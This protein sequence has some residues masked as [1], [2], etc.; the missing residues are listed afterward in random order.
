MMTSWSKWISTDVLAAE[1]SP[2]WSLIKPNVWQ[3]Q[4]NDGHVIVIRKL[5]SDS[6]DNT[7]WELCYSTV[8][9]SLPVINQVN[10]INNGVQFSF[11]LCKIILTVCRRFTSV[12]FHLQLC[13]LTL[14]KPH[15]ETEGI[16]PTNRCG[17]YKPSL[18]ALVGYRKLQISLCDSLKIYIKHT[19]I[20]A[21][22]FI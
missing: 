11:G 17:K 4:S 2:A 16:H 15:I 18:K 6:T 1:C 13:F 8:L 9:C 3:M 12:S 20:V 5:Y 14:L 22:M 7:M 19:H 10:D 21:Q